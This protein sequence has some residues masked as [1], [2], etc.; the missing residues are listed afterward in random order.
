MQ[1]SDL[2]VLEDIPDNVRLA[3]YRKEVRG[4][5]DAFG[6]VI[7]R[8]WKAIAVV[9]LLA[10]GAAIS[11]IIGA[12]RADEGKDAVLAS[13]DALAE[14]GYERGAIDCIVYLVD[15]ERV[16]LGLP[17][18]PFCKEPEVAAHYPPEVCRLLGDPEN[19]GGG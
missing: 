12:I 6:A 14:I 2:P 9:L 8:M 17:V 10:A 16:E 4:T 1:S 3:L 19:C 5:L 7:Q 11:G 13:R 18:Q 15:N